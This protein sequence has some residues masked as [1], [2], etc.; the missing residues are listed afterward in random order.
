MSLLE[1]KNI[2]Q[3][4]GPEG[5]VGSGL[6]PLISEPTWPKNKKVKI[7]NC[8]KLLTFNNSYVSFFLTHEKLILMNTRKLSA[9]SFLQHEI[10]FIVHTLGKNKHMN[11]IH[12]NS[13]VNFNNAGSSSALIFDL[14]IPDQS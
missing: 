8:L 13:P 10:S 5:Q 7:C 12:Q 11:S 9:P 1:L 14:D 3:W 2:E 4:C 6:S